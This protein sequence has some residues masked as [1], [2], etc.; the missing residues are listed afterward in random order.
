MAIGRFTRQAGLLLVENEAMEFF[1]SLI[2]ALSI[3]G[4]QGRPAPA[5]V[6]RSHWAYKDVDELFQAGLLDGY[7]ANNV[8]PLVLDRTVKQ[9]L[10]WADKTL[11]RLRTEGL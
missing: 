9:D 7:P 8:K 3:G 10:P 1:L 4:V 2:A 11:M 6:P 5:D